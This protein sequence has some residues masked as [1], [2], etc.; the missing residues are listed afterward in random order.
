MADEE[1]EDFWQHQARSLAVFATPSSLRTFRLPNRLTPAA[2][3]ASAEPLES[4]FRAHC[5]YPDLVPQSVAGNPERRSDEELV[6]AAR[7]VLDGWYADRLEAERAHFVQRSSQGR[8]STDVA[9]VARF[10][11]RGA[12]ESLFVDIDAVVAGGVDEHG[13]VTFAQEG[14]GDIL[15]EIARRAW[16]CGARLFAVREE[17]MPGGADVAATL[18]YAPGA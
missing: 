4:I 18:R 3:G 7:E 10:A 5:S 2:V 17:D 1:S 8:A 16:V 15:D 6:A 13:E 9:D 14:G 12:V 11:T